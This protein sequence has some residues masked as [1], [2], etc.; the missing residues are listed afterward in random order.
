Y[1]IE[2]VSGYQGISIPTISEID[3]WVESM[4]ERRHVKEIKES[5]F[6]KYPEIYKKIKDKNIIKVGE[7]SYI[8]RITPNINFYIS[9][10]YAIPTVKKV[11]KSYVDLD[12]V[13]KKIFFSLKGYSEFLE[14]KVKAL[15]LYN[16]NKYTFQP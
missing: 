9:N 2:N 8:I 10:D 4:T 5:F 13:N 1:T 3:D 7:K 14:E 11:L 15:N 12:N 16:Y 6:D